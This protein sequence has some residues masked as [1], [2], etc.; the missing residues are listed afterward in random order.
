MHSSPSSEELEQLYGVGALTQTREVD[1]PAGAPA[2][3]ASIMAAGD[4]P[5]FPPG[6]RVTLADPRGR[7]YATDVNADGVFV[8]TRDG[9]PWAAIVLRPIPGPWKVTVT[10]PVTTSFLLSM[11]TVPASDVVETVETALDPLYGPTTPLLE[12][13]RIDAFGGWLKLLTKVAVAAVVGV[14]VAGL[15][16]ASGGAALPAIAAGIVAFG[17]VGILEANDVLGVIDRGN[18]GQAEVQVAG[19]AGFVVAVDTLLLIDA[20]VDADPA[21][22]LQYKRRR[23]VLYPYVDASPFNQRQQRLI[24]RDDTRANVSARLLAFA[25]GYVSAAGHGQPP[26]FMGWYVAGNTGPLQEVLAVGRYNAAE[27]HGKIVHLF[28]C[29]CGFDGQIGLGRHVVSDGALAFFGYSAP[30]AMLTNEYPTFCDCDIEI[31]KALIDGRTCEEAHRAAIAKYDAAI[32]RFR[33]DGNTQA[34][35]TLELDR[36]RL[37]SPSTDPAYGNPN[38]RLDNGAHP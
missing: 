8:T 29:W 13:D 15:V 23:R 25:S 4:A 28:A 5:A 14:T 33:A 2:L 21:T 31:D 9:Q 12:R 6:A 26:Y 18:R 20:N 35:A 16:V 38:A 37:V 30:F 11:Q 22:E 1:V 24:G 10:A 3:C 36:N 19:L 17:G 27:V 34:A 7:T 32:A